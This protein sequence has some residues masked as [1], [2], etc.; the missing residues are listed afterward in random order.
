MAFSVRKA[1][2]EDLDKLVYFTIAEAVEAEGVQLV[3]DVVMK[4]IRQALEQP[5][6]SQYWVLESSKSG[7]VGSVSVMKEWSAWQ[8]GFF[9]WLQTM[10]I[11]P[12][13]RG[14]NLPKLL[15]EHVRD[16]ARRDFALELRMYFHKDNT[17][18]IK[19]YNRQGFEESPYHIR[20][21]RL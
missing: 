1:T 13:Y 6:I 9:W 15:I 16:L 12:E 19:A 7:V 3:P 2:L 18:A 10:F 8:G 5:E 20:I 4:G 21:M 17:R 11:V 14:Q